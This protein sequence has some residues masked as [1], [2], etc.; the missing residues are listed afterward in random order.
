MQRVV[1]SRQDGLEIAILTY[2]A[3]LQA[4]VPPCRDGAERSL[5][6][7]FGSIDGYTRTT[8]HYLG[9]TVGRYANR[10]SRGSLDID[11]TT[12]GL[13]QNEGEHHLHGGHAGF[14]RRVWEIRRCGS[15]GAPSVAL[16]YHSADGE[17]GYPGA[18]DVEVEYTLVHV[19]ALRIRYRASTDRRTVVNLTNHA[20]FNLAGEGSGDVLD[21]E[22]TIDADDY[23]P[24]DEDLIPTGAIASV[25]GTPFDFR[26]PTLI[27][28]R[29]A[30]SCDQLRLAGG[31]DH[32]YVL[33]RNGDE[34]LRRA[35]LLA[36]RGSAT[37]VEIWTSEPG[38]QLYT[39]NRF[40]GTLRGSGGALYGPHAGVAL[41]TQHFP[42]SPSNPQFPPTDLGPGE[43]YES[44]TELILVSHPD[45]VG[46]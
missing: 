29:I 14:D 11:G 16:G 21:H 20:F 34:Q 24:I 32:N 1:L 41:E 43:T 46:R 31:Y 27:G 38:L 36:H 30:D 6:L 8:N 19:N 13:S 22:L 5:I 9:A 10:I 25:D 2:G 7:G 18:V 28:E 45:T 17:E 42:D 15:E 4:I 3:T 40:D 35:A 23:I 12:H 26:E 44:I 33:R 37:A 39:G